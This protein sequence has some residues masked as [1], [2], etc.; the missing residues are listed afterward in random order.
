[1]DT[2]L[3]L[4]IHT[5]FPRSILL[6]HI[7][8][9]SIP[10][11]RPLFPDFQFLTLRLI[12]EQWVSRKQEEAIH[13]VE[14]KNRPPLPVFFPA[15]K[16]FLLIARDFFPSKTHSALPSENFTYFLWRRIPGEISEPKPTAKHF[17]ENVSEWAAWS[18]LL[19]LRASERHWDGELKRFLAAHFSMPW[20]H[21]WMD[22]SQLQ[23]STFWRSWSSSN[24]M[25][26]MYL[27]FWISASWL[28][29]SQSEVRLRSWN[30]ASPTL[31]RAAWD[32]FK[33]APTTAAW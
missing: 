21:V 12:N 16:S 11:H 9:L 8:K 5:V 1:M 33:G 3:A 18:D 13:S 20:R 28:K 22:A 30:T 7:T 2:Q 23:S 27:I 26:E 19:P 24:Q 15:S 4:P 25:D 10:P 32:K 17:L 31:R 14:C 6:S 29:K